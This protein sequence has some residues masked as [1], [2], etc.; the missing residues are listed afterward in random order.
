MGPYSFKVSK[1]GT[2]LEELQELDKVSVP[3]HM[4]LEPEE[5]AILSNSEGFAVLLYHRG[6]IMGGAY[7]LPSG[8]VTNLLCESD[9]NYVAVED[10]MY[11]YSVVVHPIYRK[12]RFGTFLRKIIVTE[13]KERRYVSGCTH[14]RV[15][16]GWDKAGREFYRPVETRL[17][18]NY[19]PKL[20]EPDVEF[21]LFKL[22]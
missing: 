13:G 12:K 15:A 2:A 11:V 4:F 3:E 6:K 20:A 14:V 21:Q 9:T 17:I 16:H 19:W 5:I 22:P 8:E 10:M 18:K 7:A 1:I